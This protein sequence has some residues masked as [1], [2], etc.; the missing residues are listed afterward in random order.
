MHHS[1]RKHLTDHAVIMSEAFGE[2]WQKTSQCEMNLYPVCIYTNKLL[3]FIEIPGLGESE[4]G[5][6]KKIMDLVHEYQ[7]TRTLKEESAVEGPIREKEVKDYMCSVFV[8]HWFLKDLDQTPDPRFGVL[9]A[10]ARADVAEAQG[11]RALKLIVAF[12]KEEQYGG[13]DLAEIRFR[14]VREPMA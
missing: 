11:Y 12:F 2:T 3:S 4:A 9:E 7:N 14:R 5:P 10:I 8:H 6:Y 1:S 13:L